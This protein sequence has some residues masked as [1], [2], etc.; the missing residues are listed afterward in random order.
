MNLK[1]ASRIAF[2]SPALVLTA[3]GDCL[4]G[5]G[6]GCILPPAVGLPE[7]VSLSLLGAGVGAIVAFRWFKSRK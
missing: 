1:F 7:P 6:G 4:A 5:S 3:I 2:L